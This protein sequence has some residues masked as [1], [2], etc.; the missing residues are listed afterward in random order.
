MTTH[1]PKM[2]TTHCTDTTDGL[3]VK[4]EVLRAAH[5]KRGFSDIGYHFIIQPDGRIDTGRSIFDV[6]AHVEGHNTNNIGIAMVGASHFSLESLMSLKRFVNGMR[7]Q[8][9]IPDWEFYTHRE[10]DTAIKQ[11]K[12]CPNM[13]SKRLLLFIATGNMDCIDPYLIKPD[14]T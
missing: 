7:W 11:H 4:V 3:P 8:Y 12:T 9:L 5:I 13:D 2:I 6:G 14:H 10:F 1:T